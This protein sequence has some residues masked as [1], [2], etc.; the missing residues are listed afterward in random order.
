MPHVN[1]EISYTVILSGS[2]F[3][4]VVDALTSKLKDKDKE[5]ARQLGERLL[6]LRGKFADSWYQQIR[7]NSSE[8]EPA[9]V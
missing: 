5:E 1:A 6:E 8:S 4:T 3:K 7:R 9:K 2:E